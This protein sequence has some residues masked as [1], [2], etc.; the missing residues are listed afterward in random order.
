[1]LTRSLLSIGLALGLALTAC[2]DTTAPPAG[3][4]PTV[5]MV[6]VTAGQ[7]VLNVGQ[8]TTLTATPRDATGRP[9]TGH[10]ITWASSA[11]AIIS[12]SEAGV[13]T[14]LAEGPAIITA[15]AAG[16]SGQ[17]HLLVPTVHEVPRQVESVELNVAALSLVEGS[18]V[19]LVATP[20]DAEGRP[21]PG[22]GMMWFSSNPD[23]VEVTPGSGTV[24][25]LRPDTATVTVRVH[26]KQ[27]SAV[28]EVSS[29]HTHDL[30]YAAWNGVPGVSPQLQVVDPRDPAR[31]A[32]RVGPEALHGY[33]PAPSPDGSRV[34]FVAHHWTG[35]RQIYVLD[36]ATDAITWLRTD[37]LA[38]EDSPAWSPDG[39]RIAFR[40]QE[41]GAGGRIWVMNADGTNR[42]PLTAEEEDATLF[43]PSWSPVLGP[44]GTRIAYVRSAGGMGHLWTMRDDGTDK[45]QLTAS[46]TAFDDQPAWSPDG[47]T[48][49]FRRAGPIKADIWLVNANGANARV[50]VNL[51]MHQSSPAW[52]PDGNQVAFLR[53]GEVYTTW[54]S[55]PLRLA[56]RTA[57]GLEKASVAWVRRP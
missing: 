52:S 53:G 34:A 27:A 36:Q 3:P 38:T 26:G 17:V 13:A 8:T 1:M 43:G 35:D 4:A 40:R 49:A 10:T 37:D 23:A 12:V 25:A 16:K 14:A 20:K 21:I 6:T 39:Q 44:E 11:P 42:V 50:L 45:R 56:R 57:D 24:T 7:H 9:L 32:E 54:T 46:A 18:I 31:R 55:G 51:P 19:A 48:I 33:Q 22:L 15:S 41:P 28:V 5:A 30:I 2:S 29:D 47:Q